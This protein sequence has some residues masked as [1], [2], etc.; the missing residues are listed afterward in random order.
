VFLRFADYDTRAIVS[1]KT[2]E[3]CLYESI[4]EAGLRLPFPTIAWELL[5]YLHIDSSQIKPNEWRY[6]FVLLHSLAFGIGREHWF[7]NQIVSHCLSPCEIRLA[8]NIPTAIKSKLT[9]LHSSYSN[10]KRWKTFFPLCLGEFEVFF[11]WISFNKAKNPLSM[12]CI[13]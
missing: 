4:F 8:L 6:P 13:Q 2:R 1:E 9:S 12:E 10:N 11:Y 5:C 3:V 7:D